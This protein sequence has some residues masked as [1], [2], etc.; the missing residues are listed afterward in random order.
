MSPLRGLQTMTPSWTFHG[1]GLPSAVRHLDRS[2]PSNRTMASDGA[3]VVVAGE[4]GVTTVG[5]GRLGSCTC[6]LPPGNIGVSVYPTGGCSAACSTPRA[7]AE[8]AM[9]RRNGIHLFVFILWRSEGFV[10][11]SSIKPAT[12]APG[13]ARRICNR[14]SVPVNR[15]KPRVGPA[16]S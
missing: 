2:F 1:A 9:V 13:H 11:L 8:A 15:G 7:L 16:V 3:L 4:P 6:H 12:V 5:W 14:L 10:S